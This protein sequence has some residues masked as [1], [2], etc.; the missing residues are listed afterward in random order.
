M[1][2]RD[3]NIDTNIL[4]KTKIQVVMIGRFTMLCPTIQQEELYQMAQT[5]RQ[6]LAMKRVQ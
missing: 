6:E 4:I 5:E 1:P 3:T 2:S